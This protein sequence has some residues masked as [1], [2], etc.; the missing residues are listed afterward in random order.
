M[1]EVFGWLGSCCLVKRVFL[2]EMTICRYW[3]GR[4]AYNTSTVNPGNLHRNGPRR[5]RDTQR[6][7]CRDLHVRRLTYSSCSRLS[8]MLENVRGACSSSPSSS[9]SSDDDPLP[10][11]NI[12]RLG[13]MDAKE[14]WGLFV[15]ASR[16]RRKG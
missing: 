15:V 16:L 8:S 7:G 6:G 4:S 5:S 12:S 14:L 11:A 3:S 10:W 9:F 1:A 2:S 13:T